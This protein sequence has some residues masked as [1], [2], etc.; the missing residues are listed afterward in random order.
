[1]IVFSNP[2]F[3]N[4]NKKKKILENISKV[5]NGGK[6]IK[7][8]QLEIFEAN[9]KKK[10]NCKYAHGVGNATDA[11]FLSLKAL[12]IGKGDEVI[13]TSMTATGTGLSILNTGA[14]IKFVDISEKSYC[15]N[16]E[17]LEKSIS[18]KTKAIVIVHLYGQ[19]CSM[20]ILKKIC[21]KKNIYLI[22][23]CAQAAGGNFKGKRLGTFGDIGCLSFFPTKNLACIGDGGAII[24]N[25]KSLFQKVKSMSQY[26]WNKNR[27]AIYAGINS[28][29]D[30]LQAS[31]LNVKI[32]FLD[33]ENNI[34]KRLA[35]AYLKKIKNKK[36][37]LPNIVKDASHVW[38]NKN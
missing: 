15:M 17:E 22:E 19:S 11:I 38:H 10:F 32:K 26:G 25:N 24:T 34:R 27:N 28:R 12:G 35:T 5:I 7:G 23:D 3:N 37:I 29:L 13:T 1:M 33:K 36:I 4:L 16:L 2:K 20:N 8:K 6:Y 30:E 18:K 21:K 31:I 9:L 14:K